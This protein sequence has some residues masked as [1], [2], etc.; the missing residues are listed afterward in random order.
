MTFYRIKRLDTDI[1]ITVSNGGLEE[2]VRFPECLF[3]E[4]VEESRR[5]PDTHEYPVGISVGADRVEIPYEDLLR[6]EA[7]LKGN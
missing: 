7:S 4:I 5:L 2:S 3:Y 1:I 6:L